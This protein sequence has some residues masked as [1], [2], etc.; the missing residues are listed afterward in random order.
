MRA[1]GFLATATFVFATV[2]SASAQIPQNPNGQYELK[3]VW[4]NI[5]E[6]QADGIT[7]SKKRQFVFECVTHQKSSLAQ[8]AMGKQKPASQ[9]IIAVEDKPA[10]LERNSQRPFV[11][12]VQEVD[13]KTA[14]GDASY[15]PILT[16]LDQG[17]S[18]EVTIKPL[19]KQHVQ[20][21]A[22]F[23]FTQ[24]ADPEVVDVGERKTQ[25]VTSGT[26]SQ[27]VVRTVELGET[28]KLQMPTLGSDK[29]TII[30]YSIAEL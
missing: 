20:L 19:D 27:R 21:D 2:N 6:A 1:L 11:T 15:Q 12:G 4:Q 29:A 17:H 22:T 23:S 8:Q 24:I 14:A 25:A 18:V 13:E 26:I 16:A 28:C 9:K 30:E 3:P 10:K 7:K 5:L